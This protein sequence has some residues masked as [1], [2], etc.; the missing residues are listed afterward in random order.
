MWKSERNPALTHLREGTIVG[1]KGIKA[2]YKRKVAHHLI[3]NKSLC[4]VLWLNTAYWRTV[5]LS[6][7]YF[8]CERSEEF[9]EM[10]FELGPENE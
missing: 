6:I 2:I 8:T 10:E 9:M 4:V 7:G 5:F 1:G 3:K